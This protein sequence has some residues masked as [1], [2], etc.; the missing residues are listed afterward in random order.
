MAEPTR[1]PLPTLRRLSPPSAKAHPCP[2]TLSA[3]T[4]FTRPSCQR[5]WGCRASMRR[6]CTGTLTGR[7]RCCPLR[8]PLG[9]LTSRRLGCPSTRP[10]QPDSL[11]PRLMPLRKHNL[12]TPGPI[13]TTQLLLGAFKLLTRPGVVHV[14]MQDV[15]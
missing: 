11:A 14:N 5:Q 4:T 9:S 1:I 10:P 6:C 3:G 8:V 2:G 15:P 7:S 12:P 13:R